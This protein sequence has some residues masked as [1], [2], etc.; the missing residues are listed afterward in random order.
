MNTDEC[1]L[2]ERNKEK[3]QWQGILTRIIVVVQYLAEHFMEQVQVS[4]NKAMAVFFD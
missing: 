1:T 3:E 4:V 2:R